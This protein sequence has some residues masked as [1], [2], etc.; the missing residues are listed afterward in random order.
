M[1]DSIY[2]PLEVVPTVGMRGLYSLKAPY[3]NLLREQIEYTCIA[4]QN[5]TGA[6]ANGEDPLTDIYLANGDTEANYETDLAANH[7]L[8]TLQSESGDQVTVPNSALNGLPV[9]DGV[10]YI[11]SVLG[12]SLSALPEDFDLT[13]LKQDISDLVFDQIG[14]RSTVYAATIGGTLVLPHGTHAAIEAARVANVVIQPSNSAR[15]VQ[16]E[17]EK[18]AMQAR[19][20]QLEDYIKLNIPPPP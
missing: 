19:L 8:V 20:T 3:A 6:L 7:C 12:I 1:A 2:D 18:A 11:S 10:R 4:V 16:L 15:V 5:L 14:V 17:L 9:A 13:Q